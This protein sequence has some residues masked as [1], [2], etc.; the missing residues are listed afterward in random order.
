MKHVKT[1]FACPALLLSACAVDLSSM[2]RAAMPSL[3]VLNPERL[4]DAPLAGAGIA[5]LSDGRLWLSSE[6]HGLVLLDASGA[7]LA[8]IEGSYEGADT[9]E[10]AAGQ[11]LVV[12]SID[13]R[14]NAAVVMRNQAQG[15]GHAAQID[16]GDAELEAVCLYQDRQ[17][18]LFAFVLNG[19]AVAQ[20]WLM[21]DAQVWLDEPR[22]MRLFS[23]PPEAESC[24]VDDAQGRLYITEPRVGVWSYSASAE[25][26]AARQV[27]D[28][29]A[30]YGQLREEA[31]AVAAFAGGVAVSDA[32]A[33]EVLIYQAGDAFVLK[34]RLDLSGRAP[35]GLTIAREADQLLIAL[36]DA[37]ADQY[38]SVR[39]AQKVE[40]PEHA[41]ILEVPA[42]LE[43]TPVVSVGDAADDPA[44]WVH[45]S[46]PK[47]SLVLGTN[48]KRG[49]YVYDLNGRQLQELQ[50]GPVN[51]VDVR[52]GAADFD[53]A[54]AS[55]RR[56][57][58]IEL[59]T[60]ARDSGHVAHA[61]RIDTDLSE[62]YG[63]CMYASPTGPLYVFVNDKDGRYQQYQIGDQGNLSARMVREFSL[64]SQPEG[65]VADDIATQLYAGE[66]GAG[67]WT[68]GAEPD[69]GTQPTLIKQVNDILVADVEGMAIYQGRNASYLVVSSQGNDSYVVFDAAPP[70]TLRGRFRVGINAAAGIDGASETDGL[71]VTSS[72]LPGVFAQ[73]MLI[74][75]DGRNR[76]PEQAQNFKYVAWRDI[77][78]ALALE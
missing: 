12:A 35:E 25:A 7:T 37:E 42:Q 43:T 38:T 36:F 40:E 27:V 6:N 74:V 54:A 69:A 26:P 19:A 13:E 17:G 20:Q 46:D 45:P 22:L 1:L 14:K 62:I 41:V 68:I 30:P 77:A 10:W 78:A 64:P 61:A 5:R 66:E 29:V 24:S 2:P 55:Q 44:I 21:A 16:G 75:Q 11:R 3:S 31:T 71:D 8:R 58:A 50:I 59:F 49:L 18:L 28:L 9:R 39:V 47:R 63:L 33:A 48:K 65:C 23:L 51:N 32:S 34:H 60:V 73:G 4:N 15:W 52:R 56:D 57:N 53:I 76:M 72:A 67:I 70:W